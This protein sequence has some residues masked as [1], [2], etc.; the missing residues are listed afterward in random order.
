MLVC[1]QEAVLEETARA[2]ELLLTLVQSTA[3]E[4]KLGPVVDVRCFLALAPSF[5]FVSLVCTHCVPSFP[6]QSIILTL[7]SRIQS[8]Q[9]ASLRW[10][11][12]LMEK[13]PDKVSEFYEPVLSSPLPTISSF[14]F[15]PPF[16]SV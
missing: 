15:S 13:C 14:S 10:I 12:M 4:F 5:G 1:L 16:T 3:E 2:N 11:A 9:L 7:T 6:P 8:A